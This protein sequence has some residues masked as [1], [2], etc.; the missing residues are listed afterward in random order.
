MHRTGNEVNSLDEETLLLVHEI[1]R[2]IFQVFLGTLVSKRMENMMKTS[3]GNLY[4]NR[5]KYWS[6]YVLGKRKWSEK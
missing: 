5:E 1:K 2:E 3:T 4:V 6:T